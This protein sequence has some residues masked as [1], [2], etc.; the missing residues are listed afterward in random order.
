M[1][2]TFMLHFILSLAVKGI[3]RQHLVEVRALRDPPAL[4]KLAIESI[5]LMLGEQ[6]FDWKSLR[7]IIMKDNFISLIINYKTEDVT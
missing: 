6:D 5:C 1:L 3:K 2:S 7:S 4:V